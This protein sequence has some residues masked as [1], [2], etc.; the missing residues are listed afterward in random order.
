MSPDRYQHARQVVCGVQLP[1]PP[2]L[3]YTMLWFDYATTNLF[4]PRNWVQF[5]SPQE[6]S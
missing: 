2:T 1:L 4:T 6:I 5:L 3:V